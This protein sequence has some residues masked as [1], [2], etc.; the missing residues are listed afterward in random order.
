MVKTD[1]VPWHSYKEDLMKLNFQTVSYAADAMRIMNG[2]KLCPLNGLYSIVG[3][4]WL[5][6]AGINF[7]STTASHFADLEGLPSNNTMGPVN[8]RPLQDVRTN[9]SEQNR[10]ERSGKFLTTRAP[11]GQQV[12]MFKQMRAPPAHVKERAC[13]KSV[14]QKGDVERYGELK[15]RIDETIVAAYD[16]EEMRRTKILVVASSDFVHTSKSLFWPD[17]IMIARTDLDSTSNRDESD[18]NRVR[19]R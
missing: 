17:V 19:W 18:H 5:I 1:T 12:K 13:P 3:V 10:E 8:V 16:K 14:T 4:D 11:T 9:H 15:F 7:S 6:A 2:A